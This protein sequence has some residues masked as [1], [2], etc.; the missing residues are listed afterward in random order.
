MAWEVAFAISIIG[1]AFFLVYLST[2]LENNSFIF[3]S[4]KI[5]MIIVALFI[6]LINAALP[7]HLVENVNATDNPGSITS[8]KT[9]DLINLATTN[10]K[11]VRITI[12][13][14]IFLFL[15]WLILTIMQKGYIN[16]MKRR[17]LE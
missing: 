14:F 5:M 3:D 16:H 8:E 10:L 12:T 13:V 4:M 15:L 9:V 1:S 11:V 17:G 6:V 7:I 2:K